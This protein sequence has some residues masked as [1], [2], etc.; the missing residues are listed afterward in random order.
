MLTSHALL[1]KYRHDHRFAFSDVGV[2]YVDRG[3]RGDR[4]WAFGEDIPVLE[5]QYF[6]VVSGTGS[7]R[8]PYHRIRRITYAGTVIWERGYGLA[9]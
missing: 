6:E 2:W 3:A 1:L 9:E 8:I 5:S 4:S 7:K